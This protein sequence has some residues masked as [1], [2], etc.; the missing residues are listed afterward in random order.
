[1]TL[2]RELRSALRRL[3]R[4]PAFAL[5]ATLI[6]ATTIGATA[7]VFGVVEGVLLKPFP[8]H[9]SDRILTIW[10]SSPE[11]HIPQSLV[12]PRTYVDWQAQARDFSV[13]AGAGPEMPFIVTGVHEAERVGGLIVTPNY[14]AALGVT[15]ALGRPLSGDSGGLPEVV[16]SYGLWQRRFGGA[17]SVLGQTLRLDNPGDPNPVPNHAYT[18]VGVMPPGLP[19]SV[20]L[21]TRVIF[22]PDSYPLRNS[23]WFTVY[24]RLKPGVT[25]ESAQHD[26]ELIAQ[27]LAVAYPE[28][29]ADW[30]VR[31][32]PLV[33]H[34]VGPV[35]PALIMILLAAA[36]VL[37]IGAANLANLFLVR[38]LARQREMALRVALG[39]TRRRLL[40]ELVM[41][42]LTLGVGAGAIGV[43]LA[44][45][46]VRVLRGLAPLSL[47]RLNGIGVDGG[48]VAFC[49]LAS[50]MTVLIFGVLPAWQVSRGNLA[51]FL[52][53]GGRGTGSVRHH[54]LQDG[55]VVL[56]MTMALVLLTGA[57]LLAESFV[58]FRFMD[59]GFREAGVLTAEVGVP[60]ARYPTPASRGVFLERL[61]AQLA[62]QP[63]I[64][65]ASVSGTLP[66]KGDRPVLPF[67]V[68]GDPPP[69]PS[70]TPVAQVLS[71]SPQYFRTMGLVI[72]RGRGVLPS[73]DNRAVKVAVIDE[74]LAR[75]FFGDRD[76]VGRSLRSPVGFGTMQIVGVVGT[77]KENGLIA[78]DVPAF[79]V[80][81]AQIVDG[82][83]I[84]STNI[85]VRTIGDPRALTATVRRAIAELDPM[86]PVSDVATM[87]DRL[88][89]SIG[90]IRFSTFLASLFAVVA[91]SLGLVG[92]Y[93][94]L[95]YIVAQRRR[96]IAV[97]IALGASHSRVMGDVLR[98][99]LALTGF[100]V[101]L[102]AG[103]SWML[104]RALANLFVGVSPHD[105]R[106]FLGAATLFTLS[107][108]VA[109]SGPA[110]RTTRVSPVVALTAD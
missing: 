47:P 9:D 42:A 46:G 101:T 4:S 90:T 95:A 96:E 88:G 74:L 110:W 65:A 26:L 76:P 39:A 41:E 6:L 38:C 62:A 27:R 57:G 55:L 22:D 83:L 28:T 40:G 33:D 31:T 93:S 35:R 89:R 2:W 56:Q 24:G 17:P 49:A 63:G 19:G 16:I 59:P 66:G 69:D 7:S 29:N 44:I 81:Y 58:H 32:V 20:D 105:P 84:R 36:C 14:F 102:G 37:L 34:L 64:V 78:D 8:Y 5:A 97:R 12:A 45:V 80:P 75:R 48:V 104:T 108:L 13:L 15:P 51:G 71:I 73:D 21:W 109:A 94:V 10:E 54:R 91:F 23:R 107:A 100:A 3:R 72:R 60:D 106:I 86:A 30:S 52:K 25:Q 82:S 43:G 50:L 61:V 85:A 77:V 92:V 53:E 1:M 98:R 11:R 68:V 79:Y 70:H 67:A 18:I 99:A 87:S 103:A